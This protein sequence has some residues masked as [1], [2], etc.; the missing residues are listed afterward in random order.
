MPTACLVP[1]RSNT[2][3]SGTRSARQRGAR[4]TIAGVPPPVDTTRMRNGASVPVKVMHTHSHACTRTHTT[5]LLYS[6][7]LIEFLRKQHNHDNIQ[8][9]LPPELSCDTFW[10]SN[11]E[12]RA[13][14]QFNLYTI[15]T[16]SQAYSSCLAQGGSLLSITDLTEQMYIRERLAD[17]GVMV[18]IGLNHLSERTGW[19]WSD[20]APLALVNFTS[21][22][23]S[24]PLQDNRQCGV[25]NSASGGHQWQSLSCES[26]LPY[27][28]KKTP[29]DTKTAEPLD[30]W[31]YYR[32]VC[33]EGWLAHNRYCYKALA[34]AEAGTWEDSSTACN[35]IGANLTSLHS[36]S[37]V[38][39]LLGLLANVSGSVSEVW[40][41]LIKKLSSSAVEWSDGSPVDLTLWHMHHPTHSN[42]QLC[43]KTDIKEGNWLLAQCDEK[44]PAVCRRA[45]LLSLLPTGAWDEGCPEDWKR[46]GHSCY[47]VTS[48]EQSY[49]DAVK[50]YYCKAPLVTVENRFEQA[51][52]NSL[53]SEMGA[54]GSVYYWTAL[55]DQGNRGEY[56][57]LGGHNGSTLPLLY[58]NWNR[59]QP[60]REGRRG[61]VGCSILYSMFQVEVAP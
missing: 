1:C 43:A 24:N 26:A 59:H 9:S 13:C 27:I 16:W 33:S 5:V 29:N 8:M 25:Y 12:S 35:S 19:Q 47:M 14:Y 55:Q 30:N 37:D 53:V 49:E 54:N 11:Q 38:E 46:K 58:T 36:L 21:G 56:S 28:C 10:D 34:E 51:F 42:S 52:L 2:T 18:W 44:L 4:T 39:L 23:S 15:L 31:Q 50:G 6:M 41:G 7:G 3:T 40:I 48:H 20:G 22:L 60:G 57:W 32:T 17:V 61:G 45:G